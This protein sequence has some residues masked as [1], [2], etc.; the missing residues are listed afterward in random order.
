[1][2]LKKKHTVILQYRL[3]L[4]VQPAFQL[5]CYVNMVISAWE[6]EPPLKDFVVR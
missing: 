1:M 6:N 3:Y 5:I 4:F 2:Y